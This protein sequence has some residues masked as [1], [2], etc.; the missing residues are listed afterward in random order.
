[1]ADEKVLLVDDDKEFSDIL[2][3]RMTSRGLSVQTAARS[4][5]MNWRQPATRALCWAGWPMAPI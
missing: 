3:N 4:G 5:C 1:M 2:S